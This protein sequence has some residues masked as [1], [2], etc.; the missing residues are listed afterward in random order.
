MS[1][2]LLFSCILKV[3]FVMMMIN[4]KVINANEETSFY[5]GVCISIKIILHD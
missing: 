1:I 5:I 4:K 3:N 2:I